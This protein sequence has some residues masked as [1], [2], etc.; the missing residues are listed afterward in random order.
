MDGATEPANLDHPNLG[1]KNRSF[2]WKN[3]AKSAFI[4]ALLTTAT[5]TGSVVLAFWAIELNAHYFRN[6]GDLV[7][8]VGGLSALI[9]SLLLGGWLWGAGVGWWSAACSAG[10]WLMCG[11]MQLRLVEGQARFD[12]LWRRQ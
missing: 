11:P 7:R 4:V 5:L 10:S 8:I 2:D 1:T 3:R 9:L 12:N 6:S